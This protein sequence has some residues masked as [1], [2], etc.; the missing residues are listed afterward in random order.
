[1]PV[2]AIQ[3]GTV[4]YCGSASGYGG[5]DPA[6]WIVIDS[7][8]AE[9]G[10]VLE[11][12]HIVRCDYIKKGVRVKAG[13]KIAVINPD[14]STNGGTAPHLHVSDMPFGYD[15]SAKQDPLR[16]LAGAR[17]PES[18]DHS[19][20]PNAPR[21]DY[22]EYPMWS[23]K[24]EPRNTK[25]D[26]FILHT[27]EGTGNADS[28]A[29]FL[30]DSP[31]QVSYHYTVSQDPKDNGVTVVDVVDT[32]LAA[33]SVLSANTRS[34]NLCFAGSSVNWSTDQWMKQSRAIDVAAF[35]AV[36]DCRKYG[37]PFTV[38][39]P[40]YTAG[41]AGITDHNYVSKVLRDG[42]HSDV[43]QNFPWPYFVSCVNKWAGIAPAVDKPS[44]RALLEQIVEQ[45]LGPD[46]KGWPQL[47]GR[48]LVE[49]VAELLPKAKR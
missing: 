23:S 38:I 7:S 19:P 16:R 3:S 10:G 27:Q 2:Y 13:Q 39:P 32:D 45:L 6:G 42:D 21:P 15:P 9:G 17:D 29:R 24:N 40:P 11:Y 33:W 46:G 5:P 18:K 44:D 47:G 28:L 1:M 25:V 36:A 26:L 12:G 20:M 31:K 35:L 37:I 43:G 4:L 14:T 30:R 41:R 34:I 48:T 8:D 49:A 22:N